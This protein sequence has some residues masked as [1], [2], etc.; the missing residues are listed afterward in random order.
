[1]YLIFIR[2][3]PYIVN[4]HYEFLSEIIKPPDKYDIPVGVYVCV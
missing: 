4:F 1:M 2:M 3:L